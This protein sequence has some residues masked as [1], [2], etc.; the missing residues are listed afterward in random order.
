MPRP[1]APPT[2]QAEDA[3]KKKPRTLT[4][5]K[6][7]RIADKLSLLSN[8][9]SPVSK[10]SAYGVV[11]MFSGCG[12]FDLGAEATSMARVVCAIDSDSWAAETYRANFGD[13]T[14]HADIRELDPPPVGCDI[15][16]A[17]PPCQDFSHLWNHDGANT[18][19]GSLYREVARYLY[20]L[21]PPAFVLENVP[22]LLSANHGQAWTVVRQALRHPG[23]C[24]GLRGGPRYV[25]RAE[26]VDMAD[27]GVPQHRERLIV[28]G[29]RADLGIEPPPIPL[30]FAGRHRTVREA[31]ESVPLPPLGTSNHEVGFDSPDVVERLKLISPGKN[32]TS[33]PV[34]HRLAVKGLISHVYKRLDPDRP[35]YT[36]I[37]SGGGGTHGYHYLEPRRLSNRERA[38]LQSFPD[39]F[40]FLGPKAARKGADY[41]TVRRL[42]GNAVP[43]QGARVII[44]AVCKKLEAI[45]IPMRSAEE[46]ERMREFTRRLCVIKRAANGG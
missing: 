33:I 31:L 12:G 32:Y 41:G 5:A 44:E 21:Q 3:N 30:P 15:L 25:I 35:S 42:I 24:I 2:L 19:R 40:V 9:E 10:G 34:G 38:R 26:C 36:I 27:L 7:R 16:L 43:P 13:H 18:E 11:T 17:S 28:I 29:F 37:A 46:L 39:S 6:A 14:I 20:D 45:G 22:G 1:K 23:V 4:A 8:T